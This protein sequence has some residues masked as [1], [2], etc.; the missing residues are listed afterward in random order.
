MV[1]SGG[2]A[3]SGVTVIVQSSVFTASLL[4]YFSLSRLSVALVLILAVTAAVVVLGVE[5]TVPNVLY[6]RPVS[7]Q[8]F[9]LFFRKKRA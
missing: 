8:T 4:R 5:T 6:I 3:S 7:C 1:Y 2:G 9:E